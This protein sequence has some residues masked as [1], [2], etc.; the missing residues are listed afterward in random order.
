VVQIDEDN[1]AP[2]ISANR[3][4][5]PLLV[6]RLQPL[7]GGLCRLSYA[8]AVE[9]DAESFVTNYDEVTEKIATTSK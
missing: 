4:S 2:R 3:D 8:T 7:A 6:F 5:A 9:D 1:S